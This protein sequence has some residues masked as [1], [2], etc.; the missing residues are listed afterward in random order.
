MKVETVGEFYSSP[1][2]VVPGVGR[3]TESST[4]VLDQISA[5]P[6]AALAAD[7]PTALSSP[8]ALRALTPPSTTGIKGGVTSF[9]QQMANA[10]ETACCKAR[11]ALSVTRSQDWVHKRMFEKGGASHPEDRGQ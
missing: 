8:L 4:V 1:R 6:T 10:N 7:R 3:K 11:Y 9:T 5:T 2:H